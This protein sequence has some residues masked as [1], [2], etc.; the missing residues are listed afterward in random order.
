MAPTEP[1]LQLARRTWS[2]GRVV[3]AAVL[4]YPSSRYA[5]SARYAVNRPP[6]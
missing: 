6:P 4:T 2:R 3:T 5:L 1:A